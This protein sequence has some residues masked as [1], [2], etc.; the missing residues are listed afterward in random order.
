[1]LL[2]WDSNQMHKALGD[3][4]QNLLFTSAGISGMHHHTQ[5]LK[6]S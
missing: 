6:E 5:L 3:G 2:P 4:S 1:M